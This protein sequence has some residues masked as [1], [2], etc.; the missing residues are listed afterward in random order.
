VRVRDPALVLAAGQKIAVHDDERPAAPAARWRVIHEDAR[1]VVVDKPA[2]LPSQATRGD[3][4]N[5]LDALVRARFGDARLLHRLDRD[6]SGLVLFARGSTTKE[7]QDA[8]AAGAIVRV[9]AAVV[10]GTP[11]AS[12]LLDAPIGADPAD[13]RKRKAGVSGGE[14]A[15]TR[16]TLVRAGV[17]T[18]LV[19]ARLET[20]RRHQIRVH[21]AGAGHPI[22]GDTL[23]GGP[24]APRLCLHAIRL[25]WPGGWAESPPPAELHPW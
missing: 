5:A 1:V 21:L 24:A 13:P 8:L 25:E 17:V 6:A 12:L 16:V 9:Y 14:P 3:A 23:Y 10:A 18:S 15:R 11:P 7:L 19:E 22:A 20:G 2:G 4:A